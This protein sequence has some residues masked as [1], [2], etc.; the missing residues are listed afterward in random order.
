MPVK[1]NVLNGFQKKE[2]PILRISAFGPYP[3]AA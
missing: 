1:S 2:S 3:S